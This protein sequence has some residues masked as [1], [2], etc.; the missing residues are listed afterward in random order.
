LAPGE[1]W[2]QTPRSFVTI[3]EGA[4]RAANRRIESDLAIAWHVENF[5]RMGKAFKGLGHYLA[6]LKPR[7]PQSGDE[8]LAV[9]QQFQAAGAKM[10]IRKINP[11][12]Q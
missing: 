12:E 5:S 2:L 6:R 4:A 10:T 8:I 1:F 11:G 9:F 7:K 3:M